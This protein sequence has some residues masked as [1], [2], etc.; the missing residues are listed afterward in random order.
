[1]KR[2]YVTLAVIF[3]LF[4]SAATVVGQKMSPE[5]DFDRIKRRMELREEMHRRMLNKL[6]NGVGPDQD[7]FKDMEEILEEEA[8]L[9]SISMTSTYETEWQEGPQGKILVVKP[10]N[11]DQQ[12]DINVSG[13]LVTISGKNEV[14]SS[15][16][17]SVSS[18]SNSFSI[19]EDCDG[20]RVKID[21]KDG[22]ILV[23]FPYRKVK[24]ISKPKMENERQPLP[25]PEDAVEI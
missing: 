11:K 24:T 21:Q 22:K 20:S 1:M 23:S 7:M 12:L 4:L 14:K 8:G 2:M 18:F 6:F 25:K 5:S 17:T 3:I 10:K 19:P 13:E 9:P 15:S 16:G